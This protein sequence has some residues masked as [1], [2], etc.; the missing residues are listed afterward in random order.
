MSDFQTYD[1]E[2]DKMSTAG[3]SESQIANQIKQYQARAND[4]LAGYLSENTPSPAKLDEV[5]HYAVLNGGKR[6]RPLLVYAVGEA[7]GVDKQYL[8]S[9]ACAIEFIHAYS[10]VH[11]DLPAMDDDDVRRGKPTVHKAYD[12]ATAILV[13]DALHALA[14]EILSMSNDV[15]AARLKAVNHLAKAA[16]LLGMVGGQASD[17]MPG[18]DSCDQMQLEA[19]FAL[20]TGA[21]I[22]ASIIMPSYFVEHLQPSQYTRLHEFA[23]CVGL[24]F[25]IR[26]DVLDAEDEGQRSYPGRFGEEFTLKRLDEL[27]DKAM[28]QL[29]EFQNVELLSWLT[30][31]IIQRDH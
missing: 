9:I 29:A 22:R 18:A 24:A 4:K 23:D 19:L 3:V 7:L 8:D 26:D 16:G 6:V 14:F 17:L 2:M 30:N 15:Q 20:K 31:Y 5:M 1:G 13:G 27:H 10:L 28:K 21:L 12:E 11:D 25:Q